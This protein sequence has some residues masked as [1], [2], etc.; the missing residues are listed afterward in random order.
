MPSYGSRYLYICDLTPLSPQNALLDKEVPDR[1][2]LTLS[3]P[4]Y[5]LH[6]LR[7]E[8]TPKMHRQ[9]FA[10]RP[11]AESRATVGGDENNRHFRLTVLTDG[12]LRY[13]WAADGQF[14][15]RPSVFAVNR[16]LPTPGFRV[17]ETSHA[18]EIIT[19]R[20]HLTYDKKP[21]SP[22]GFS[23]VVKG[24]FNCHASVWRYGEET[25]NLGGTARTLDEA[26]GRIPLGPGVIS[27]NGFSN[28]DD[29]TSMLFDED[30]FVASRKPGHDRVDGYLF[31]Y[32]HDYRAAVKA[33]YNLS[34]P[35]PLLPRWALGNW[36][37]RYYAYRADE[38]LALMD[39][40]QE[41]KIPL[42]VA[43]LDMDWHL[44]N[45]QCVIKSGSTG[46]TGYTWNKKLYPDPAAFL[47]ELHRRRLK[48]SVNDHPADGVYSYEDM[49]EE[50]S[51]AVGQ[52]ASTKD[53]VQ[54]D[55]VDPKFL[56]AYFDVLHRGLERAGVDFIWLDWQQVSS[57]D[58]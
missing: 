3:A 29:S 28:I 51:K 47:T 16:D 34:G 6:L 12:L 8:R 30:G 25:P 1:D 44:V 56:N 33:L 22:S 10:S 20:F 36:W 31:A 7:L 54:F 14:E 13:E 49:Y 58:Y 4:T 42:S 39:R 27:R 15:D 24:Y 19:S 38:Y 37:S 52:D 32:G 9:K 41:E 46:W 48:V 43:V 50:M 11:V 45:D 26:D 2:Y 55:I 18:I 5:S 40:F 23:V 35:Q 21:F 57:Q 17:K 53:P